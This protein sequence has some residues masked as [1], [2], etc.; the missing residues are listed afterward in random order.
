MQDEEHLIY[1][2][3]RLRADQVMGQWLAYNEGQCTA[4]GFIISAIGITI[5]EVIQLGSWENSPITL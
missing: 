3:A 2:L 4:L 1:R 5:Y